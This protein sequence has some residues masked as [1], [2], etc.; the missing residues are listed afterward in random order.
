MLTDETITVDTKINALVSA[1]ALLLACQV[2]VVKN[3]TSQENVVRGIYELYKRTFGVTFADA[4][5][6]AFKALANKAK[7]KKKEPE[8]DAN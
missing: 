1:V 7:E 8:P 3:P 4:Y 5:L 6:E 2:N